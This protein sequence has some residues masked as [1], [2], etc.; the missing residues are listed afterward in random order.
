MTPLT[1]K[2]I[3]GENG[4]AFLIT[5]SLSFS[6]ISSNERK[7]VKTDTKS[8]VINPSSTID[9]KLIV[10]IN[11]FKN[12]VAP[13]KRTSPGI[14]QV[15]CIRQT[16]YLAQGSNEYIINLLINKGN[17][18]KFAKIQEVVPE[19][20]SAVAVESKKDLR[21]DY[22]QALIEKKIGLLEMQSDKIT[23][24]DIFLHLTTKEEA[25]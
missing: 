17:K 14:D 9:P 22:A 24:E 20:Y 8:I 12:L 3:S 16:P 10:D 25:A 11:D 23:L 15:K 6:Y 7:S 5:A 21:K 18:E 19:G 1:F 4:I 2:V 13:A